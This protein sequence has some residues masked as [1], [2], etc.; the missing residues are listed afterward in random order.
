VLCAI[1]TL[2][3]GAPSGQVSLPSQIAAPGS[4]VVLPLKIESATDTI[5]GVQFDIQYDNSAMSLIATLGDAA[6]SSGK[7]LYEADVAPNKRRFL[8]VGLNSNFIG[9]GTLINL[10]VN[11]AAG[12]PAGAF[13]LALSN[14]AGTDPYG[15][16]A[17][18]TAS[19]GSVTISG[20][21]AQSV[22]LQPQGVLNAASVMSGPLAPGELFTFLGSGIGSATGADTVTRVLFDGIPA[23][24]VFTSSNQIEGVVPYTIA[25]QTST[26]IQ[27]SIGDRIVSN[28]SMPVTGVS[29]AVFTL[30]ASGAGQGAILNSDF[31]VNSPS[32]PATRGS[33]VSLFATGAGQTEP[34]IAGLAK[35]LQSVRVRIGGQEAEVLYA[36]SAPGL[37]T[38]VLQVNCRIPGGVDSGYAI[39]VVLSVG[40]VSSSATVTL[41]VQ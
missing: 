14:S 40:D 13:P 34:A 9:N 8:I 25:G 24:L 29:P 33:V 31:G 22:P 20:S 11:V 5:S 36:G 41:A 2:L 17:T 28:L 10:F 19:D 21:L 30:D 12:A 1:G 23:T 38:G 26:N 15:I 7:I 39:P 32:N 6:R 16:F 35:P 27:I 18:V 4:S 37:V 3:E